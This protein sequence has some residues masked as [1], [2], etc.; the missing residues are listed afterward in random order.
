M[1][2]PASLVQS[3][4]FSGGNGLVC[5]LSGVTI[6]NLIVVSAGYNASGGTGT[7]ASASS[8]VFWLDNTN[9][10][11]RDSPIL[12]GTAGQMYGLATAASVSVTVAGNGPSEVDA[13]IWEFTPGGVEYLFA[14]TNGTSAAPAVSITPGFGGQPIV[15]ACGRPSGQIT[16]APGAPW[17]GSGALPALG[18][19]AY[20]V[21]SGG[22]LE[23]ATWT[24]ANAGWATGAVSYMP[25]KWQYHLELGAQFGTALS[26]VKLLQP[27]V[28]DL[29]I[30][31]ALIYGSGA[32]STGPTISDTGSG[33][34]SNFNSIPV[35]TLVG[36]G[37]NAMLATWWKIAT[38]ADYNGGSG[39]TVTVAGTVGTSSHQVV[40]DAEIFRIVNPAAPFITVDLAA[41]STAFAGSSVSTASWSPSVGSAHPGSLD[42][43]CY[44][45]RA[46]LIS[47]AAPSGTNTFTATSSAAN[48]RELQPTGFVRGALVCQGMIGGLQASA[49]AGTNVFELTWT[50]AQAVLVAAGTFF[51]LG[52]DTQVLIV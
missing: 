23:T 2:L 32:G 34:W 41:S 37:L 47:V 25:T 24:G 46:G 48:I 49:T 4:A 40:C 16:A 5:T 42:E 28:G 45:C 21:D 1:P 50:G 15:A 7:H 13:T 20:L 35:T 29:I 31:A 19:S 6:G 3:A 51:Y 33:G 27:I 12:G 30:V 52:A 10:Q 14:S 36:S 18:N 39:F 43:L 11:A 9:N 26:G 22:G 44:T 17:T 38:A 8:G